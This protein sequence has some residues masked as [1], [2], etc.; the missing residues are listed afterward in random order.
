MTG[1]VKFEVGHTWYAD[2]PSDCFASDW[3]GVLSPDELNFTLP[4]SQYASALLPTIETGTRTWTCNDGVTHTDFPCRQLHLREPGL[5]KIVANVWFDQLV[6]SGGYYP[7]GVRVQ[8]ASSP[9]VVW[10][11]SVDEI[12]RLGTA[13]VMNSQCEGFGTYVRAALTI[14]G[15]NAEYRE[16]TT[17]TVRWL[18]SDGSVRI[19]IVPTFLSKT[20]TGQLDTDFGFSQAGTNI[21]CYDFTPE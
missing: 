20:A 8:A 6:A 1:L 10:D 14:N 5:Y 2:W 11:L 9:V 21:T 3:P 19:H 18:Y 16:G 15:S 17:N 13:A 12:A 4:T 7:V